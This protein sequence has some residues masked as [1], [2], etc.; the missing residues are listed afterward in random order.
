MKTINRKILYTLI[1][2]CA[3]MIAW[4]VAEVLLFTQG[5]FSS[6]LIFSMVIGGAF[7]IISGSVFGSSDGI[8]TSNG[9]RAL[10]GIIKGLLIGCAGGILGFVSGQAILFFTGEKLLQ[11][12]KYFNLLGLPLSRGTGWTIMGLFVGSVDALRNFSGRRLRTGI[13]GGMSGGLTGGLA[14]EY[15]QIL[16][17]SPALGRICGLLL[18][19]AL[20]GLCYGIVESRLALGKF[21]VLNGPDRGQVFPLIMSRMRIGAA[22]SDDIVLQKYS[23][24]EPKHACIHMRGEELSICTDNKNRLIVNDSPVTNHILKFEDVIKIGQAKLM[25]RYN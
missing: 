22:A 15:V 6:Y 21:I 2:I 3:G 5:A 7:G 20:L 12:E 24:V 1:G 13:I 8:I 17:P 10:E 9:H 14:F 18:F 4:P 19:G 23:G 25:Y 11:S 16:I